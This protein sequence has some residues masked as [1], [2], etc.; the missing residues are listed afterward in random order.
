MS[1]I[2]KSIGKKHLIN[3]IR[4][5]VNT[6]YWLII[7]S[8]ITLQK[9]EMNSW[10]MSYLI[11]TIHSTQTKTFSCILTRR[12]VPIL[13]TRNNLYYSSILLKIYNSIPWHV[14]IYIFSFHESC[15]KARKTWNYIFSNLSSNFVR[16]K[17][18][19]F[20]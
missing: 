2:E 13:P 18:T 19:W 3:W 12:T 20:Y 4:I 15:I 7:Y 16:W 8:N 6:Y 5:E 9:I 14:L 1:F 10:L 17:L 11:I